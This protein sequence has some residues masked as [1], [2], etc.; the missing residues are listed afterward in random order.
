[1]KQLL[2]GVV[3]V[4]ACGGG[5]SKADP[6]AG[7]GGAI[8]AAPEAGIDAGLCATPCENGT[9][10]AA[11]TCECEAGWQGATCATLIPP[12]TENLILWLDA[13]DPTNTG[14]PG[15]GALDVW[16][17]KTGTA[18]NFLQ[19]AEASRPSI[20]TVNG[21]SVVRF[22]GTDDFMT[23]TNFA[24]LTE[25]PKYTVIII[26]SGGANQNA[27][28]AGTNVGDDGHGL[29]FETVTGQNLRALHRMPFGEV[30]G[31]DLVSPN[32]AMK[33]AGL[34]RIW[35]AREGVGGEIAVQQTL[36]LNDAAG[37]MQ[38]GTQ[39]DY[40]EN[41]NLALGRLSSFQDSRYLNG[42]IAEV[43]IYAAE[44]KPAT[45]LALAT[46]LQTKWGVP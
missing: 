24:G 32:G 33:L 12:P 23:S 15:V 8:D 22:D 41:L 40:N 39:G 19:P 34:N 17:D 45:S 11:D 3:F 46:Y 31:D 5:G 25:V 21:R 18:T 43:L 38:V 14:V 35:C 37:L 2:V 9:C 4:W 28:L 6:D 10:I 27:L 16:V 42:E 36:F 7:G 1:M 44:L 20:A 13:E 30:N 26:A 29:Y